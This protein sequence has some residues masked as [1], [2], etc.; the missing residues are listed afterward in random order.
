MKASLSNLRISPRKVRLVADA[1]RGKTVASALAELN[2]LPKRASAPLHKLL[3]SA[4]ANAAVGQAGAEQLV[5]KEIRVDEA[6]TLK[7]FRPRAMGR[8][9]RINKRSSRI[10]VVLGSLKPKT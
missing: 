5:V 3:R 9:A 6:P 4:A 7:R 2:L 10:Q 8:G 1:V